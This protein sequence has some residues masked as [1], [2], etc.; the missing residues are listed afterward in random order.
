MSDIDAS[1]SDRADIAR[2]DFRGYVEH[3][4]D[5][6]LLGWA[7]DPA[8][9]QHRPM[10][11]VLLDGVVALTASA[12]EF[13]QDLRDA[14]IGDGAY[15]FTVAL[16]REAHWRDSARISVCV[17]PMDA[18]MTLGWAGRR[19]IVAPPDP[20]DEP[21]LLA[22]PTLDPAREE[23][24]LTLL[25]LGDGLGTALQRPETL[26]V[27]ANALGE[28]GALSGDGLLELLLRRLAGVT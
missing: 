28:P 25:L 10:V 23:A 19:Q 11:R 15:G 6:A 1:Q 20:V 12:D 3:L 21:A 18:E 5:G 26:V 9:P 8:R 22:L 13:R 24:L 7:F 27:P 14:G 16:P 4:R 17:G 2:A